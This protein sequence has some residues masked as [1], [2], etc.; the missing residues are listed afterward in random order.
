MF[1]SDEEFMSQVEDKLGNVKY[2]KKCLR[3]A[4][5]IGSRQQLSADFISIFKEA[6]EYKSKNN[7]TWAVAIESTLEPYRQ[8]EQDD[9]TSDVKDILKEILATLKSIETKIK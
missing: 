1:Y 6:K 9:S 7:A 4:G 2:F 8:T 3:D 5:L